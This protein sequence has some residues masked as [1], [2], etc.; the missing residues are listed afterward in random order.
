MDWN[1]LYIAKTGIGKFEILKDSSQTRRSHNA[2]IQQKI[3][4]IRN[5]VNA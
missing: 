1:A 3:A 2:S 4:D 5:G